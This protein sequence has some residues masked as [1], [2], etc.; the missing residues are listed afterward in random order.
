MKEERISKEKIN[1]IEKELVTLTEKLEEMGASL[2]EIEDIKLELKGLK[3]FL[4]RAYPDFKSK[5]PEI[6]KKIY[7]K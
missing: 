7:K 2:E 5:F 3:L 1:L 4:G 6:M